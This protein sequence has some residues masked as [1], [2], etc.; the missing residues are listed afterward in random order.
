LE[1]RSEML[2]SLS[3]LYND[4]ATRSRF[5]EDLSGALE[6]GI[7][8]AAFAIGEIK[9]KELIPSLRTTL[10]TSADLHIKQSVMV[11]LGKFGEDASPAIPEIEENMR[12]PF[13]AETAANSLSRIGWLAVEALRRGLYTCNDRL[14]VIRAL[15]KMGAHAR[16][17]LP[18]LQ[19]VAAWWRV[20]EDGRCR[21]A[22][23]EAIGRIEN[24]I[25][26]RGSS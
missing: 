12:A 8:G 13:L 1:K 17:A 7:S 21:I 2:S 23:H 3:I 19:H 11:A 15:G 6:E 26:S 20:W 9:T 4:S 16:P 18:D 24:G 25:R 14:P 10:R 5:L 22:A